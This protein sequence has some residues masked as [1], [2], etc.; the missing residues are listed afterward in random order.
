MAKLKLNEQ[1]ITQACEHI[2]NGVPQKYV[3]QYLGISEHTWYEWLKHGEEQKKG[4]Y[5]QFKQSVKKAQAEAIAKNV[6]LIQKA[7]ITNWQAAAWWLERRY[8]KEFGRKDR[9][10]MSSNDGIRIIIDRGEK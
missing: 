10:D 3:A 6:Q 2:R 1:L 9:M 4:I 5:S 7:A 8:P